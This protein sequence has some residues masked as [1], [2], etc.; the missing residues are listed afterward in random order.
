MN[1]INNLLVPILVTLILS[2][3]GH[4]KVSSEPDM[5]IQAAKSP[6]QEPNCKSK[7]KCQDT[8]D[9]NDP[10]EPETPEPPVNEFLPAG[11]SYQMQLQGALNTEYVA[12][13]YVFD[14]FDVSQETITQIKSTGAKAICYFSAGTYEQWRTDAVDFAP[15]AIGEPLGDWPGENWLDTTHESVKT[16]MKNRIQL[17]KDKGCDAVDPD[18]VDSHTQQSG[19][20]ISYAQQLEY[21]KYLSTT[22]HDNQLFIGLKNNLSQLADLHSHYDFAINESCIRWNECDMLKPFVDANKAVFHVEYLGVSGAGS[23]EFDNMCSIANNVGMY[24]LVLPH[25]LDDAYRFSCP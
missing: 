2:L 16:V 12:D 1:S 14:L 3:P 20:N 22:A 10:Q 4:A 5:G 23:S 15:E 11:S 13:A 21:N 19:F 9:P 24:S 7:K 25:L 8:T 18:N 17:A 6:Q